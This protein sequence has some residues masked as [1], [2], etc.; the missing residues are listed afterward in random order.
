MKYGQQ[1]V[2]LFLGRD[3]GHQRDYS[4]TVATDI[5]GEVRQIIEMA[6]RRGL[7]DP[8]RIPGR[9]GRPRARADGEGDAEQG[10]PGPDLRPGRQAAAAQHVRGV[11]PARAVG[12]AAG[13]D[14]GRVAGDQLRSRSGQRDRAGHAVAGSAADAGSGARAV[15]APTAAGRHATPPDGH[16]A[17]PGYG[18]PP[19]GAGQFAGG[20]GTPPAYP[21]QPPHSGGQPH[22]DQPHPG[23]PPYPGGPSSY[24]SE[25][26]RSGGDYGQ[27]GGHGQGWTPGDGQPGS[28]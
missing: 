10:R 17:Q 28:R 8:G 11:R 9:A 1:R 15:R 12:Q 27:P 25:E 3:Y 18:Q 14:P 2:E 5:D 4:E 13:A 16:P 21:P 22:P 26:S 7:G 19:Y 24:G 20:P 23:Q 6:P